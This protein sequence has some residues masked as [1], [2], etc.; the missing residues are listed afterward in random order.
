MHLDIEQ[1]CYAV[2]TKD[3]FRAL[4]IGRNRLSHYVSLAEMKQPERKRLSVII[5][6]QI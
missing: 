3:V 4:Q 5:H 1:Y 6:Q 2:F